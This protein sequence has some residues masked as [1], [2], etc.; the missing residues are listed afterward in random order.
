MDPKTNGVRLLRKINLILSWASILGI[1]ILI[2]SLIMKGFQV[3]LTELGFIANFYYFIDE[4]NWIAERLAYDERELIT[5]RRD[6]LI[7]KVLILFLVLGLGVTVVLAFLR[8]ENF[9]SFVIGVCFIS[10]IYFG[11]R[12]VENLLVIFHIKLNDWV[13]FYYLVL[14][15]T[16]LIFVVSIIFLCFNLIIYYISL[17]IISFLYVLTYNALIEIHKRVEN[18]LGGHKYFIDLPDKR[19][20]R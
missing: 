14:I 17:G 5:H 12:V 19:L 13:A 3:F 8:H 7:H 6:K 16:L 1:M 15:N 9:V 20:E 4:Y 18:N 2:F 10:S 11:S